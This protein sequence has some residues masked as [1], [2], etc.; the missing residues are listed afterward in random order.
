MCGTVSIIF[1]NKSKWAIVGNEILV[2]VSF[3]FMLSQWD[4]RN[5]LAK[6]AI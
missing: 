2:L 5:Q 3:T 4:V 1:S 6:D